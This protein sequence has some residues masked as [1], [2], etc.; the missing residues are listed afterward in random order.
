MVAAD[1]VVAWG[2]TSVGVGGDEIAGIGVGLGEV[3]GQSD[4]REHVQQ[5]WVG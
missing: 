3:E 2:Q 4:T 5:V 1:H